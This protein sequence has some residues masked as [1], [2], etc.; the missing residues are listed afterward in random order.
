M[1][2]AT[3]ANTIATII[4]Y[5]KPLASIVLT[6][7][8]ADAATTERVQN[9]LDGVHDGISALA[10]SETAAESQ[11]IVQRILVDAQAVL[12][13]AATMP[14]PPPFNVILMVASGLLPSLIGAV[15]MLLATN[16]TVPHTP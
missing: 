8:R 14:L 2:P 5:L 9:A 1:T 10:Q 15:Q 11:P 6:Q 3:A 16:T 4:P 12:Q 13:V 7:T